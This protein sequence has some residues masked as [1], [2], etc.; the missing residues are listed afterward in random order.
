MKTN[1]VPN[2]AR[3]LSAL[4]V[5]ALS[6]SAGRRPLKIAADFCLGLG[7]LRTCLFMSFLNLLGRQHLGEELLGLRCSFESHKVPCIRM[8]CVP[9]TS[10]PGEI[11][12]GQG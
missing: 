10:S 4:R 1:G 2:L 7:Q 6:H 12:L 9:W 11:Y 8:N 3:R 5:V